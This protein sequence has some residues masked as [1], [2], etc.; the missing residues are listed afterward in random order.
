MFTINDSFDETI[1]RVIYFPYHNRVNRYNSIN[2]KAIEMAGYDVFDIKRSKFSS[3]WKRAYVIL[4]WVESMPANRRGV[5]S[6]W[7]FAKVVLFV[8]IYCGFGKKVIWVK[9]NHRAHGAAGLGACLSEV[10]SFMLKKI[11]YKQVVLSE[12][13]AKKLNCSYVPHPLYDEIF[14]SSN[15]YRKDFICGIIGRQMRYKRIKETL[16]IWPN[17]YKLILA[18]LPEKEYDKELWDIIH[19]RALNVTCDFRS[20]TD[21]ELDGYMKEIDVFVV[22]NPPGSSIVSGG[23]Y[24]AKTYGCFVL[25]SGAD[26]ASETDYEYSDEASLISSL[27]AIKERIVSTDKRD[28]FLSMKMKHGLNEL[29]EAWKRVL[30]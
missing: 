26:I 6:I 9:H 19:K 3:A 15:N 7:Q 22:T 10:V 29:A 2:I 8:L 24:L 20:L 30:V 16:M 21:E 25:S 28:I 5:F 27:V 12:C 13:V 23:Y 17:S 18:G 4:N 11:A 1:S 14:P